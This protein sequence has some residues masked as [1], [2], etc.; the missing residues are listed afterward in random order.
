[1]KYDAK[2][3]FSEFLSICP[4]GGGGKNWKML[5]MSWE[6]H[7]GEAQKDYLYA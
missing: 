1:M 5:R 4:Q 6:A 3:M 7:F 2:V